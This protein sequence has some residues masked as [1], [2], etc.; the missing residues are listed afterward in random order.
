MICMGSKQEIS[1][2]VAFVQFVF[3]SKKNDK[4]FRSRLRNAVNPL[5]SRQAWFDVAEFCDLT[6]ERKRQIYLLIGS[7][8]ALDEAENNGGLSIGRAVFDS[9]R[10]KTKIEDADLHSPSV[11]RMKK[12]LACRNSSEVCRIL[13]P[14][15]RLVQSRKVGDLDYASLLKDL[16]NFDFDPDR[17]KAKWAKDFFG[18]LSEVRK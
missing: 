18:A 15:I 6:D 7:S 14:L 11:Q 12:I 13:R 10:E 5:R 1:R 17:V 2:E 4:G 3:D 16:N 8:I 9:W